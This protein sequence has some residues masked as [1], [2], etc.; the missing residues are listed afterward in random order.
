MVGASLL[1]FYIK[2]R[3]KSPLQIL[4]IQETVYKIISVFGLNC[5]SDCSKKTC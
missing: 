1:G 5:V 2:H 4:E 3:R